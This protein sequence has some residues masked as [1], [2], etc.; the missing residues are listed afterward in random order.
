[1]FL[2]HA[3]ALFYHAPRGI[4]FVGH[5]ISDVDVRQVL[6]WCGSRLATE[7]EPSDLNVSEKKVLLLLVCSP[8]T[9]FVT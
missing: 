9:E 7:E 4:H 6:F 3:S 1:M 2:T 8:S 5:A